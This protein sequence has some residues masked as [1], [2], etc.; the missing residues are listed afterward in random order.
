MINE[1]WIVPVESKDLSDNSCWYLPLS[2]NRI[3]QGW[4]FDDGTAKFQGSALNDAVLSGVNQLNNL[5]EV[6][7]G[8]RVGKY[9]VKKN[10][11]GQSIISVSQA[12]LGN[13]L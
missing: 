2:Q 3:S 4:F 11:Q 1:G 13:K 10:K 8:F 6:L 7:T 5:V 12:C 9:W